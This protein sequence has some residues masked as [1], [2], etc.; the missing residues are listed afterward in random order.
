[1]GARTY[2]KFRSTSDGDCCRSLGEF[3]SLIVSSSFSF[4]HRLELNDSRGML[5]PMPA[6]YR[7]SGNR[8]HRHTDASAIL[9]P[10]VV[11]VLTALQAALRAGIYKRNLEQANSNHFVLAPVFL[12][13]NERAS[14]RAS[15]RGFLL[16]GHLCAVCEEDGSVEGCIS[17]RKRWGWGREKGKTRST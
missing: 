16:E 10:V 6:A 2:T 15:G 17:G 12:S 4:N 1:M 9:S 8:R 11:P 5:P 3:R 14:E 13:F 7:E